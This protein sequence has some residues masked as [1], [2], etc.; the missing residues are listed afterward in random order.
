VRN[1]ITADGTL[2]LTQSR[3]VILG[4]REYIEKLREDAETRKRAT[5][6]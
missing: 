1:S 6:Q 5:K 4:V 3:D 2:A